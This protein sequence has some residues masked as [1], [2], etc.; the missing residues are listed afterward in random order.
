MNIINWPS[1]PERREER[2]VVQECATLLNVLN[3]P[4]DLSWVLEKV[5]KVKARSR[6]WTVFGLT[7]QTKQTDGQKLLM[8]ALGVDVAGFNGSQSVFMT[9][10]RKRSSPSS[11]RLQDTA[12]DT[13]PL[14][15]DQDDGSSDST[16]FEG[17]DEEEF[18]ELHPA[19]RRRLSESQTAPSKSKFTVSTK[20]R[21][22]KCNYTNCNKSYTKPAR[23]REHE[24]SHTGEA[25]S[26][27][28]SGA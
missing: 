8:I 4:D 7:K 11:P 27:F 25:S 19:K 17:Y 12:S 28:C 9:R 10:K 1:L 16:A 13:T 24:R 6:C 15:S 26:R 22:Y 18:D 21:K 5:G 20:V 3:L 23:L 14:D 2:P